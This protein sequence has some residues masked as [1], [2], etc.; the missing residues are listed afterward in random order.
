MT[1]EE[2]QME[3]F[4]EMLTTISEL[5]I[6]IGII[7][8]NARSLHKSFEKPLPTELLED[9]K[10]AVQNILNACKRC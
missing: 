8:Q 2:L 9:S 4:K 6:Q 5:Y 7:E 1:I 3:Q 10:E